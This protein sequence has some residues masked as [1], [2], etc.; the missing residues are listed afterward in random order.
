MNAVAESGRYTI[1][2]CPCMRRLKLTRTQCDGGRPACSA[3]VD[4]RA[5]C[6]YSTEVSKFIHLHEQRSG[7]WSESEIAPIKA[8]SKSHSQIVPNARTFRDPPSGN[9]I[10]HTFVSSKTD[11]RKRA[12]QTKKE[13]ETERHFAFISSPPCSDICKLQNDFGSFLHSA[14]SAGLQ[15][16]LLGKWL[17]TA[18]A[19]I[20]ASAALDSAIACLVTGHKAKYAFDSRAMQLN[21]QRYG[22][23][24]V[25]LK[26]AVANAV[27]SVTAEVIAATKV[28][29]VYE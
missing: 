7:S 21:Q 11:G 9:G 27:K 25:L 8:S 26:D 12:R 14:S 10:Y 28:L 17:E 16:R 20:G 19:R 24:L 15:L 3:C 6:N 13:A 29:M 2:I 1:Q 18:V 4:R 5:T 22:E 23:S